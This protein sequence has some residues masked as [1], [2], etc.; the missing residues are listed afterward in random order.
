MIRLLRNR[1]LKAEVAAA[2]NRLHL[3]D[4]YAF[5]K[6]KRIGSQVAVANYHRV[7]MTKDDWSC[8]TLSP[9]AFESQIRY[10]CEN[11]SILSLDR[12][13]L[14]LQQDRSL[15]KKTVAITFDDGYRDNYLYA[16]P[17]L[18]KYAVPATFFLTTGHIGTSKLFWWDKVGY[19]VYHAAGTRLELEERTYPLKSASDRRRAKL[20]I[21]KEL[22]HLPEERKN[23]LIEKLVDICRVDIPA[24]LG[25]QLVLSWEEVEEMS[26]NGAQFGAH[27]A[28]HPIL[29]NLPLEQARWEISRSKEDLEMR[30]Q[31]KVKFFS[32]PEGSF[33]SE[34]VEIVKQTGFAAAVATYPSWI[35]PRSDVY[36]LGRINMIE[37]SD[38]SAA[39]LCGLLGDLNFQEK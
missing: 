26:Q 28:T 34:I 5:L 13:L 3:F 8:E 37:D 15:P 12:L 35:T 6:R 4:A 20:M 33:N 31:K 9:Q 32:Y 29:A 10:F 24:D 27:S 16:F 11:F 17:I 36:R 23:E 1:A 38:R 25:K 30:L 39:L 22:K 2:A 18:R 19:V 14:Y 21:M 7:T